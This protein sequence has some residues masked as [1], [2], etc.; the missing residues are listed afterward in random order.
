SNA[1]CAFLKATITWS[2]E[3]SP[4]VYFSSTWSASF[5]SWSTLWSESWR[6]SLNDRSPSAGCGFVAGPGPTAP[7]RGPSPPI[8]SIIRLS[9][10]PQ[11]ALLHRLRN[12]GRRHVRLVGARRGHHVHRLDHRI[13]VREQHRAA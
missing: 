12:F 4:F 2:C 6:I 11:R 9:Q 1:I 8:L 5:W 3:A 13:D 7:R 10:D